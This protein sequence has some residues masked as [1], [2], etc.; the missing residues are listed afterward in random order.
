MFT[1]AV[2]RRGSNWTDV[3]NRSPDGVIRS[4][5]PRRVA[6]P[7]VDNVSGAGTHFVDNVSPVRSRAWSFPTMTLDETLHN[8]LLDSM[9]YSIRHTKVVPTGVISHVITSGKIYDLLGGQTSVESVRFMGMDAEQKRHVALERTVPETVVFSPHIDERD[10]AVAA[11]MAGR[12]HGF[13]DCFSIVAPSSMRMHR[14]LNFRTTPPGSVE[15]QFYVDLNRIFGDS[16]PVSGQGVSD[17]ERAFAAEKVLE[18]RGWLL[19]LFNL[20]RRRL[21][22]AMHNNMSVDRTGRSRD[23]YN[24]FKSG[25]SDGKPGFMH[26]PEV[27]AIYPRLVGVATEKQYDALVASG[28]RNVVVLAEDVRKT[29]DGPVLKPAAERLAELK[30]AGYPAFLASEVPKDVVPMV[31][32]RTIRNFFL[33]TDRRVWGIL[34]GLGGKSFLSDCGPGASGGL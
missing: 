6:I 33:T 19:G 32:L 16:I 27:E 18:F 4:Y 7:P 12:E 14:A 34:V 30:A 2:V 24:V 10:A 1:M 15:K 31:D 3:D 11:R 8:P 21:V 9:G 28:Y 13:V 29:P 5:D 22:V 26:V 20:D 25:A 17:A 23:T